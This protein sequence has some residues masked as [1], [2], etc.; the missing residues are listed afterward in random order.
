MPE[1]RAYGR[2]TGRHEYRDCENG[3]KCFLR[4]LKMYPFG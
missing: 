4:F 2:R 1:T 3:V